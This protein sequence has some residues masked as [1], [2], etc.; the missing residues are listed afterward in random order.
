MDNVGHVQPN[1]QSKMCVT[2]YKTKKA[3]CWNYPVTTNTNNP[4]SKDREIDYS[5]N[6][7]NRLGSITIFLFNS[8]IYCLKLISTTVNKTYKIARN[9][10]CWKCSSS[11]KWRSRRTNVM[12]LKNEWKRLK[13]YPCFDVFRING[14]L[15]VFFYKY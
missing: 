9:D 12:Y 2:F 7:S 14:K 8:N 6:R 4:L 15:A 11:E 5:L 13:T 3:L 1:G 10:W